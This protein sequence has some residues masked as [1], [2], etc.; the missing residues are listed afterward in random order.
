MGLSSTQNLDVKGAFCDSSK[1]KVI[2]TTTSSSFRFK[3][4]E[5]AT[6]P[7]LSISDS[8]LVGGEETQRF[9]TG[10]PSEKESSARF[11]I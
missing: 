9:I 5:S 2:L 7:Q 1:V 11:N 3:Y 8:G 4:K 10:F 6:K